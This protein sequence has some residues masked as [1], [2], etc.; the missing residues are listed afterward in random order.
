MQRTNFRV[1]LVA[2][3]RSWSHRIMSGL[4]GQ[5]VGQIVDRDVGQDVGQIALRGPSARFRLDHFNC[6][7]LYD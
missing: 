7:G 4:K 1:E 2:A 6:F 5:I 3:R